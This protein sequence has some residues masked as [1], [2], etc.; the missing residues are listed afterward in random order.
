MRFVRFTEGSEQPFRSPML[1]LL[2]MPENGLEE[3]MD[4]RDAPVTPVRRQL[5]KRSR[6]DKHGRV[7]E[8]VNINEVEC[9]L[10]STKLIDF[11]NA[12]WPFCH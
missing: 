11:G 12:P 7:R 9:G 4:E 5:R 2:N 10:C 1:A 3:I 8:H 6:A